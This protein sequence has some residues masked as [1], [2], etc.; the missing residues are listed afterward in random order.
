MTQERNEA[1]EV[2]LTGW[3]YGGDALGRAEDGR[4]IFA[5]FSIPEE[6]VR[7][8]LVEDRARWARMLPQ[9][10]LNKSPTRIEA[11]CPHFTVCGGCHY[12]H[13]PYP[14]QRNIKTEIVIEQLQRI[15]GLLDPPVDDMI[16]SPRSWA[17][18]NHMR[19]QVLA[20]GSLG[21][22]RFRETS[23]F[24]LDTCYLPEPDLQDVWSRIDLPGGTSI[25]QIGIRAGTHGD[26][27]IVLHGDMNRVSEVEIDF[28]ASII[29]QDGSA[30]RVLA[31][32]SAITFEIMGHTFRVSPP[33]FFQVNTSILPD[34]VELVV[35]TISPEPGMNVFDLFA[36]V[37]LFSVYAS[38]RGA[39]VF[40]VEESTSACS[41]FEVNLGSSN[42][43]WLYEAP[44]EVALL[45]IDASADVIL[46]DPPRSGLSRA[47]MDGILNLGPERI[48]Y[49]SCDLG[50]LSRDAK[51]LR[52]GGFKLERITPIDLFPQTFHIE[53]LSSWQRV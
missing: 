34:L 35:N 23:P 1:I 32:E 16:P 36:G 50:T 2:E 7:G 42:D 4:M 18:R 22:V 25:E 9:E 45:E 43:A 40:A 47:T 52:A 30:W 37:G 33:S 31:G 21:L 38:Q 15:G 17:Y 5:P 12:Q 3:A 8:P 26:P 48:V 20:D 49:L 24:A 44:V 11:R 39:S 10:W 53:T 27:M 19:Y 46:V 6:K 41:D 29:W 14:Q 51:R 28:P 13:L